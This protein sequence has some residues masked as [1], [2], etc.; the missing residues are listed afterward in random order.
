MNEPSIFLKLL[1]IFVTSYLPCPVGVS[2][3]TVTSYKYAYRLL[4]EFIY[5]VKGIPADKVT[6][7]HLGY[8]T[9]LEFLTGLKKFA[10]VAYRPKTSDCQQSFH[11]PSMPRTGTS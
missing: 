2:S 7:D 9:L 8:E 5:S 4:I 6:F 11:F 1:D 3:N 10:I